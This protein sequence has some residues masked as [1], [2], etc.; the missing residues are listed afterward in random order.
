M[1]HYPTAARR[2]RVSVALT[3]RMVAGYGG[4]NPLG[5]TGRQ[6]LAVGIPGIRDDIQVA[7]LQ[8]VFVRIG[9]LSPKVAAIELPRQVTY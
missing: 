3:K 7:A 8:R 2:F 6:Q 1:G 9:Q 4:R 5:F